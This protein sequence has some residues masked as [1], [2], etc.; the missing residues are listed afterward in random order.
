MEGTEADNPEHGADPDKERN[1]RADSRGET[2]TRIPQGTGGQ[3]GGS[4][5]RKLGEHSGSQG[6]TQGEKEPGRSRSPHNSRGE[7]ADS[8]QETGTQNTVSGSSEWW[9]R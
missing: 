7:Q 3:E 1:V 2:R 5:T 8:Q 9:T 4:S 6:R